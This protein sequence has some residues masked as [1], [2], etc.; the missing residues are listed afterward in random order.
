MLSEND[1]IIFDERYICIYFVLFVV[2]FKLYIKVRVPRKAR[3]I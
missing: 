3:I 1:Q 2:F